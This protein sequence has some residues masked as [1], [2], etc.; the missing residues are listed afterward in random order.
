[1]LASGMELYVNGINQNASII[2]DALTGSIQTVASTT[3]GAIPD[4]GDN[5][6]AFSALQ[7]II[8][9]VMVYSRVLS[10][11][12]IVNSVCSREALLRQATGSTATLP[13]ICR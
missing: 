11:A 4:P 2:A 9:D 10:N 8:D 6:N 13:T 3:I 1:M 7:G 12:E 5:T